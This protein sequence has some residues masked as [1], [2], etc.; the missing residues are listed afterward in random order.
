MLRNFTKYYGKLI[1]LLFIV[2]L[3]TGC[4]SNKDYSGKIE[5]ALKIMN[6]DAVKLGEPKAVGDTLYFGTT[7]MNNN[8]KIVDELKTKFG[9]TATF[10]VKNGMDF[11]RISTN[12]MQGVQRAIG[13]KLDPNGTVIH[14][15]LSGK[16]Y[17]GNAEIL[18]NPYQTGYQPII[19]VG[20][21]VVGAYYVGFQIEKK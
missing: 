13:T 21:A 18:G 20:G 12:V 14:I 1:V 19:G 15:L 16:S 2:G 7:K 6:D 3:M 9:C 17:S 4:S 5:E 10:F 8:Y 11:I